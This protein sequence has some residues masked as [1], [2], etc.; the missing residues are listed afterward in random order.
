MDKWKRGR[1]A[2][3]IERGQKREKGKEKGRIKNADSCE[4]GKLRNK[5]VK[6]RK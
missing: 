2:R 1:M 3:D 6:K 5:E 4:R